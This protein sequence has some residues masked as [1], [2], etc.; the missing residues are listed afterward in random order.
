MAGIDMQSK[1]A[2]ELAVQ[3]P[4]RPAN[5]KLPIIYGLKCIDFKGPEFTIGLYNQCYKTPIQ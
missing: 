1:L 5:S 4:I 2:Y 3:G